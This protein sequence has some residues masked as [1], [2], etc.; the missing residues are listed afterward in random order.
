MTP[1][2]EE[3]LAE[4]AARIGELERRAAPI[5]TVTALEHRVVEL[6]NALPEDQVASNPFKINGEGHVE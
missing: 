4:L 6:E 1:Q 2:V 3:Q 5:E